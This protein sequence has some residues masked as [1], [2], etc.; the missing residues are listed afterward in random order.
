MRLRISLSSEN[1]SLS[2]PIQY[3][4]LLQGLIYNN[5]DQVLSNWLHEKGHAY[6]ARRFKLFTFSRLFGKRQAENGRIRFAGPVHFYLGAVN[7]EVLGSLAEHLLQKPS[8]R[9]GNAK[10][11]VHEIGVEPKPDIELAKPIRVRTL[12]PITTYSTLTTPEG[13]KKTYYYAPQEKEWAETLISNLKRKAHALGWAADVDEDLK[14][15]WV[16]P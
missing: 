15:A 11:L 13:R 10:C 6:G 14:E 9:L 5:L 1:S 4:H 12:S 16:R 8:V 7:G 3:N 2:L